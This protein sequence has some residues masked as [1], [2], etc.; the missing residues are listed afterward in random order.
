MPIEDGVDFNQ[1]GD[2]NNYQMDVLNDAMSGAT[3]NDF[4]L[5]NYL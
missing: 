5:L 2:M 3:V 4:G 1:N